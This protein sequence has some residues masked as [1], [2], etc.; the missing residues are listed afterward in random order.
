MEQ[1]PPDRELSS[2]KE[3][4]AYLKTS[5][6]TAQMWERERG[7]PVRRLPGGRGR[8]SVTIPEI[9]AWK[10]SADPAADAPLAPDPPVASLRN[11]LAILGVMLLAVGTGIAAIVGLPRSAP[12]AGFRMEQGRLIVTDASDR[13]L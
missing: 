8:V 12:P 9:E 6:R 11:R 13:E 2:W 1:A 10:H 3:I 5:V 4:S 7:L